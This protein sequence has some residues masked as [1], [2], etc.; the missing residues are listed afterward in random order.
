ML[1]FIYAI[2]AVATVSTQAVNIS[3]DVLH[4]S[5]SAAGAAKTCQ[6]CNYDH[7]HMNYN[8]YALL[9]CYANAK[10]T[11]SEECVRP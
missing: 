7:Y 6:E 9:E 5:G 8:E 11:Y 3:Y 4:S 2:A 10:A 1:K